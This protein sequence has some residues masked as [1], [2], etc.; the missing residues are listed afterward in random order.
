MMKKILL[1]VLVL[2]TVPLMFGCARSADRVAYNLDYNAEEFNLVRR[3]VAI[4]GFTDKPIFEMVGRCSIET[5]SS[6]VSG[7]MEITCKTGEDNYSKHFVYL[8]DNV[9]ITVQQLD[10]I[11]VPQYHF[12]MVFAPQSI[13]PIPQIVSGNIGE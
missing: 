1:I 7:A 12:Q 9:L 8:S 6:Y 3:I 2:L 4:N 10:G 5:S 13:L 11:D